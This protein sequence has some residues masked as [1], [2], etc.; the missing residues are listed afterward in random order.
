MEGIIAL[1]Q[2]RESVNALAASYRNK[3]LE[4]EKKESK[5]DKDLKKNLFKINFVSAVASIG[6]LFTP[7]KTRGLGY[8]IIFITRPILRWKAKRKAKKDK[9]IVAKEKDTLLAEYIKED[10]SSIEFETTKNLNIEP[11]HEEQ[12]LTAGISL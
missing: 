1:D 12:L 2:S 6:L 10:G 3:Y 8:S 4:L 11:I 7:K 9:K 5:I